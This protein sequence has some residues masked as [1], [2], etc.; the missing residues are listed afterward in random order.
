MLGK[1]DARSSVRTVKRYLYTM[2][3]IA[4]C[5]GISLFIYRERHSTVLT[6]ATTHKPQPYTELYF[7]QPA[8][9]PSRVQPGQSLPVTFTI[10]NV[11]AR[12]LTYAYTVD[13]V[14]SDGQVT[15]LPQQQVAVASGRTVTVN[16]TAMKVPQFSG[17]AEVSLMLLHRPEA[18]H[19]W[20]AS[21]P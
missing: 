16:D 19:F 5:L 8:Q 3:L 14:P 9:L 4:L 13:F 7:S 10:H 2:G 12:D 15:A 1:R 18:I 11:E 17:R 6:D 21:Q 20:V